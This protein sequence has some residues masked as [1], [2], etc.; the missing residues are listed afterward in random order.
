[1]AQKLPAAAAAVAATI[2]SRLHTPYFRLY[3]TLEE[4]A[5]FPPEIYLPMRMYDLKVDCFARYF[6]LSYPPVMIP[7][8]HPAADS[9][10]SDAGL[11][12]PVASGFQSDSAHFLSPSSS[13]LLDLSSSLCLL[14]SLVPRRCGQTPVQTR[15]TSK[16]HSVQMIQVLAETP[17]HHFLYPR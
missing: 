5:L 3:S 14:L 16:E 2:Q 15:E 9:E 4:T 6:A 12:P 11:R 10:C 1:M 13:L 7:A 8:W 17:P